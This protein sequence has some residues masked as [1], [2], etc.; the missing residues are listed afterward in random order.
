MTDAGRFLQKQFYSVIDVY[1]D[2]FHDFSC[3]FHYRHQRTYTLAVKK[4]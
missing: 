1:H 4:N 3:K 2:V